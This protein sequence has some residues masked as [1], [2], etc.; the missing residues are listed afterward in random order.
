MA[1]LFVKM[2][3]NVVDRSFGVHITFKLNA[4][5]AAM[6]YLTSNAL[7]HAFKISTL[8]CNKRNLSFVFIFIFI[9]VSLS[10]V[11]TK[12]ENCVV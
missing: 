6:K 11:N 4:I 9:F 3:V 2:Y 7:A 8:F 10:T 12:C 5:L 1:T